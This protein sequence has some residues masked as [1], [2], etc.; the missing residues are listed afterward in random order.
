MSTKKH[1][2][3]CTCEHDNVEFCKTCKLVHC[4][5]CKIEW[6]QYPT[7]TWNTWPYQGYL[8]QAQAGRQFLGNAVGGGGTNFLASTPTKDFHP[9]TYNSNSI[10]LDNGHTTVCNHEGK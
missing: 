8:G 4:L 6:R 1:N 2:H 5:D 9:D 3:S 7:Y 10:K